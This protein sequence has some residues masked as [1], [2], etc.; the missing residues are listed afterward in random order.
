[1]RHSIL[2]AVIVTAAATCVSASGSAVPSR[3]LSRVSNRGHVTPRVAPVMVRVLRRVGAAG[4]AHTIAVR[5]DR[6]YYRVM[7]GNRPDCFG[8][9]TATPRGDRF[10]IV[11]SAA[12]PSPQRPIL[13]SSVFGADVG[14]ALHLVAVEGFA[15]DG[16]A[17]IGLENAA[18]V[19]V[20]RIPV[21]GNVYRLRGIPASAV[22]VVALDASGKTLFA[23]PK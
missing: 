9:G 2:F 18:G 1:M 15:A 7:R 20:S 4:P 8:I 10:S 6:R 22:R 12:F 13:D 21:M 23:I 5:G 19:M 3:D 14:E 11:C 17:T 16:V